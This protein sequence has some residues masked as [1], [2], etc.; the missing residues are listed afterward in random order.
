MTDGSFWR[1]C[2]L[3]FIA[4]GPYD[5]SG[6][7]QELARLRRRVAEL[8][9]SSPDNR[10]RDES[11]RRGFADGQLAERAGAGPLPEDPS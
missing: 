9:T 5:P 1:H 8:E 7:D 3:A 10:G 11:Y 4:R 6:R 2:W